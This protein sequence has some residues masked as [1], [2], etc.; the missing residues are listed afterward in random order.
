[1]VLRRSPLLLYQG[2]TFGVRYGSSLAW[3]DND[4]VVLYINQI[5]RDI[6]SKE[7]IDWYLSMEPA[8][9]VDFGGIEL[10]RV[11]DMRGKPMPPFVG[12]NVNS[13]ANFGD[14]IRLLA[15]E[16]DKQAVAPGDEIFA[17]LYLRSLAPMD[18]NYNVSVR[19]LDAQGNPIWSEDGWPWGA[20]TRD[21]PVGDV[22]PDGHHV[23][24]PANTPPGL[25]KLTM[26]FYEPATL[27]TLPVLVGYGRCSARPRHA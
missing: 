1:M 8:Y 11:Y 22:R 15:H 4:F 21:W 19:L 24:I 17:Q 7:A 20:A 2:R 12:L 18:I 27:A 5:Q 13:A 10:A 14:K 26:S 16:L 6:P 25:Y 9:R 23:R 3:L